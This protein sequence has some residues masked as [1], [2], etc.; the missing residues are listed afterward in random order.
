MEPSLGGASQN[1]QWRPKKWCPERCCRPNAQEVLPA[2][3]H[4]HTAQRVHNYLN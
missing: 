2:L 3:L 1:A 4:C